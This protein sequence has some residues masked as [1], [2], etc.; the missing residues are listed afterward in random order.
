MSEGVAVS[1][2]NKKTTKIAG[3]KVVQITDPHLFSST[4][5]KL[6]GLNTDESLKSVVELVKTEHPDLDIVLATGERDQ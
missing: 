5:G 4:D 1:Q 3:I 2:Q 6:L